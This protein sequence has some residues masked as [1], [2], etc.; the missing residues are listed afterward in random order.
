[1]SKELKGAYL[2][3]KRKEAGLSQTELAKKVN[4]KFGTHIIDTRSISRWESSP[5]AT[6][7]YNKLS[8]VAEILGLHVDELYG[9][10]GESN[11]D[12]ISWNV[13]QFCGPLNPKNMNKGEIKGRQNIYLLEV[14]GYIKMF[15]KNALNGIVIL[16]E[17]PKELYNDF[18]EELKGFKIIE[19]VYLNKSAHI[20]TIA[21]VNQQSNWREVEMCESIFT[22]KADYRNRVVE[23]Q[24]ED[25]KVMGVHMHSERTTLWDTVIEALEKYPVVIGDFNAHYNQHSS[26]KLKMELSTIINTGYLD[27]VPNDY[28]TF[29]PRSTTLDHVLISDEI[30]HNESKCEVVP[31][32]YSDHAVI[33]ANI[34]VSS[35]NNVDSLPI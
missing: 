24:C 21:I 29:F 18:L 16:Q 12:I 32:N 30:Y 9:G 2:R 35:Q 10:V 23:V 7:L 19:P 20:Y 8:K 34:V 28:V 13:N 3:K 11:Y 26:S 15:L 4:E 1:M 17:V 6:P 31:K 27:L 25:L 14:S 5:T 33:K 22:E